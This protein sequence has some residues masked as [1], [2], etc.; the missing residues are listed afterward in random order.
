MI[1]DAHISASLGTL[2]LAAALRDA[3]TQ[4]AT[5]A[6]IVRRA[7]SPT[8]ARDRRAVANA[9]LS[10]P[11]PLNVTEGVLVCAQAHRAPAAQAAVDAARDADVTLLAVDTV[12]DEPVAGSFTDDRTAAEAQRRYYMELNAVVRRVEGWDAL[13]LVDLVR[14]HTA[15]APFEEV[16]PLV[17]PVLAHLVDTG[18]GLAVDAS[19]ARRGLTADKALAD[20]LAL[21]R[22]LGGTVV[23]AGSLATERWMVGRGVDGLER[24]LE[25][26][27]FE[28]VCTYERH[29]PVMHP[30]SDPMALAS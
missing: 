20:I 23:T 29:D 2:G 16:R 24:M 27:G 5:D 10:S 4:G 17:E 11:A 28:G 14:A 8:A 12:M 3:A 19:S 26:L 22:E 15:L 9:R 30:F 7:D 21:Y 1:A 6:C 13:A 25:D 18:R